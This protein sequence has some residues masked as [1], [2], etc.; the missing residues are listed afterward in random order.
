METLQQDTNQLRKSA[1]IAGIS[2]LIMTLA[3]FFSYGY[4]H[5]SLITNGESIA[6]LNKIQMSSGLFSAEIFGWLVILITDVLVSWAFY[7]Y[8][9]PIH[10]GYSLLAAWLRL[11]YTAILAIAIS[12]LIQVGNLVS[13]HGELF[14]QS[15]DTLAS[16]VMMSIMTFES[17]WSL[18]LIVFGLH[19]LVV[20]FVALKNKTIPKVISILLVLAG[21]SYML[22][23]LLHGFFPILKD[24][25][26]TI[27]T[28]LSIPMIVGELGFGIWL[29]IKGGKKPFSN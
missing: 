8:L 26:S 10:Q 15:N 2:L 7:M 19:L 21:V 28:I 20:G 27:E 1:V 22:V 12:N 14:N 18:G 24:A 3:A 6:T 9:K 17:V 5:S 25:T 29:L 23:H 13:D 16:Q 4:V 11:M